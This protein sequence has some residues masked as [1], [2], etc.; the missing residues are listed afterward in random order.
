M[1]FALYRL[2]YS[3][4]YSR[5]SYA[6][7]PL[8]LNSYKEL[9][10]LSGFVIAPFFIS[11]KT[12]LVVLPLDGMNLERKAVPTVDMRDEEANRILSLEEDRNAYTEDFVKFHDAVSEG[13]FAKLVLSRSRR[14]TMENEPD[15]EKLFLYFCDNYPRAM[16]MLF[17]TEQTGTW[18]IASPEILVESQQPGLG[19][20]ALAGTMPFCEGLPL[21]SEKNKHE[22]HIVETYIEETISPLSDRVIK[23]GPHSV[24]AGNLMHL[25]TDFRFQPS[26]GVSVGN[27]VACLHPTPAVCGMPKSEARE[28]VLKHESNERRYYS[29]FAGPL[30]MDGGTH[31]FVSLRCMNI[32]GNCLTVYAGGGIMPDSNVEDEWR[33]TE[34]K[35]I[36]CYLS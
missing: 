24:R 20:I 17:N 14:L 19:T 25:R 35:M 7:S 33:E 32:E 9:G 27:I 12:P 15:L 1:N 26:E 3:D 30:N 2:P 22:Q 5:V 31:L 21:W 13:S 18:L 16:V 10:N 6:G 36:N 34:M 11:G 29:G 23:D 28:F 8:I 4:V